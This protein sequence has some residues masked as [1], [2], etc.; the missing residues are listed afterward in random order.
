MPL[1]PEPLTVMDLIVELQRRV[2]ELE[3]ART[4]NATSISQGA[5]VVTDPNTGLVMAR[6]GK[7]S[8]GSYGIERRNA[9]GTYTKL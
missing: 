8:D 3:I 2:A 7:L 4:A 9:D 1:R 6:I 5:T